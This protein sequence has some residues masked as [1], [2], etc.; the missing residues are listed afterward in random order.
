MRS[1][2]MIRTGTTRNQSLQLEMIPDV[3]FH[4][5]FN[6]FSALLNQC[7]NHSMND[8]HVSII[9]GLHQSSPGFAPLRHS[10]PSF[11]SRQ[12]CSHS[13]ASQTIKVDQQCTCEGFRQSSSLRLTG[14]R[15]EHDGAEARRDDACWVPRSSVAFPNNLT[16]RKRLVVRQGPGMKGLSPSPAPISRGLGPGAPLRTLL[17][18]T[19]RTPRAT[20][21]QAGLFPVRSPLLRESL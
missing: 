10:S 5:N 1:S 21:S 9:A 2:V 20:D 15:P 18:T 7:R 8:L 13:N 19:I 17:R 12:A 4:A 3:S 11:G 6:C 14:R 16:R